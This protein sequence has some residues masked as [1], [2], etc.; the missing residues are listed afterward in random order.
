MPKQVYKIEQFHGGINSTSDPRDIMP[1]ELAGAT[2]IMV[3]RLGRV[4]TIGSNVAH[5]APANAVTIIEGYG[6]FQFSHDRKLDS[7]LITASGTHGRSV[8]DWVGNNSNFAHADASVGIVYEVPSTTT[9]VVSKH[10]TGSTVWANTNDIYYSNSF[11]DATATDTSRNVSGTPTISTPETGEDYL[12]MSDGAGGG[13]SGANVDIYD[14]TGDV[15][16]TEV[17][18]LGTSTGLRPTF[19]MMD[20][21]LRVSDGNYTPG[22]DNDNQWYGYIKKTHFNVSGYE[23]TYDGWYSAD[24]AIASPTSGVIGETSDSLAGIPGENSTQTALYSEG[25]FANVTEDDIKDKQVVLNLTEQVAVG[26]TA[27]NSDDHITTDAVTTSWNTEDPWMMFP[28][29]G[30][31]FNVYMTLA[32]GTSGW[33]DGTYELA[34]TFIYDG[35]QESLPF[36]LASNFVIS[37]ALDVPTFGVWATSPYSPRLLGGRIY[38]RKADSDDYW[39]LLID[40]NFRDGTRTGLFDSYT[41]WTAPTLGDDT[42]LV[43][44]HW[45]DWDSDWDEL[46]EGTDKW[47]DVGGLAL[48]GGLVGPYLQGRHEVAIPNTVNIYEVMSGIS[49]DEY[50]LEAKFKTAV[51]ANRMVYIGNIQTKDENNETIVMGDAMIKSPTNKIDM[52]PA[53]RVIEVSVRDG[54]E[55]VKLEEYADRILQFKKKKMH[56]INVSQEIEFLEE[57]YMHKGVA[58]PAAV[59][60]T[61][62]GIAW[63]NNIGCYL[64]NGQ[65]VKNLLEKGGVQLIKQSNWESFITINSMIGFIPKKRQLIVVKNFGASDVGDI[66][67]FDM[68]TQSWIYGDSKVIDTQIQTNFVTDWNNDLVHA[69]TSSTGTVVKWSD[70]G[71]ATSN[72]SLKT[73]DIDFGQ[74]AQRKKVYKIYVSYKG[75]GS[76][77]TIKYSV[78][79]ETD[80]SDLYAFDSANLADKSSAENLESWHLAELKPGTSSQSNNIYSFQIVFDGTAAADFEI[81]DISIVYRLKNVR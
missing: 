27:R 63:V 53:N 19:Y 43:G 56:L 30:T 5:D 47:E 13:G 7:L 14:K 65:E 54:D 51:V 48:A 26:I 44:Y 74:P 75:D 33:D 55:I 39:T 71:I 3:D 72:F 60:K 18:T 79:G 8:G 80:A 21:A 1:N 6:L 42:T 40:I 81:N 49:Q 46:D 57:T 73:K 15:W 78:N 59:C 66:Y 34:S 9:M 31:G 67:L 25:N 28:V 11:T 17:I 69:H 62:F 61:D 45:E 29:A 58:H 36:K 23:D 35:E 20:G 68:I 37:G 12:A 22:N 64:Y 2:D 4:R 38:Y 32:E 70:T 16:L 41:A 76:S 10:K 24:Q 52:F 77:V 50:S